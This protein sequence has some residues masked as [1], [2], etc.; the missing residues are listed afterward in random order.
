M[1]QLAARFAETGYLVIEDVLNPAEVAEARELLSAHRKAH[2]A[3]RWWSPPGCPGRSFEG[4][5]GPD[6]EAGRWQC[7]ALFSDDATLEPLFE[8]LMHHPTLQPLVRHLVGPDLCLRS[9]WTMFRDPV[10]VPPPPPETREVGSAW[11]SASGVHYQMWH[12]EE[13]GVCLPDHPYFIHS[14]QVKVELDECSSTTHCISTVP[15]SVQ[16]K[17]ALPRQWEGRGS[18]ALQGDPGTDGRWMIDREIEYWKNTHKMEGAV[19]IACPAGA[20]IVFNNSNFHAGTV[21]Q[22][23]SHRRS[24]A[25][26]WGH[27]SL[28][29]GFDNN[30][31]RGFPARIIARFPDELGYMTVEESGSR[32]NIGQA[33]STARL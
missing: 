1:L 30:E 29:R 3:A 16:Q 27:E 2:A 15:E 18:H 32:R 33:A 22:T 5:Y 7:N 21:R 9:C 10:L 13:G 6:A 19:D 4:R 24:F 31:D 17:Q 28:I 26:D 11:A 14:L 8:R 20:A 25:F 23:T 12:R